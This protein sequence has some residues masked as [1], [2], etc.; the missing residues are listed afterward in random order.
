VELERPAA[1]N[2]ITD[3]AALDQVAT[4]RVGESQE[5]RMSFDRDRSEMMRRLRLGNLRKLFRHR[6]G[7]TLPD[8]DAGREDLRE[9]LLPISVSANAHIKMPN[10]I[11]VWAP[12][13]QQQEAIAL[14][15]DINRTP[16][17]RRMPT[18]KQLG[19]RLHVTNAERERLK[20]WTIAASDLTAQEVLAWRRAKAKARMRRLRHLHGRK[21]RAEYEAASFS[22]TKPWLAL[23]ISRRTW[24]RRRRKAG[25]ASVCAVRLR[26]AANRPV[27]PQ[28]AQPPRKRLTNGALRLKG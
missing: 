23:G 1:S 27:P 5:C 4:N 26:S 9:L 17:R 21:P 20:L 24:E 19:K 13:M 15:D 22:R 6:Y 11:E 28:Q 3:N 16:R 14:I 8:D 2:A 18:G 10:A 25:D 12:W 7:P